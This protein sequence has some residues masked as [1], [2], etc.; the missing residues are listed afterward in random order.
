V[1]RARDARRAGV[2]AHVLGDAVE[3]VDRDVKLVALGVLEQ[4]VVALDAADLLAHHVVEE[5][6]AVRGVHDVIARLEGEGDRGGVR[7]LAPAG[8]ARAG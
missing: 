4:E 1:F 5:R 2:R 3:L 8:R 7:L 6:D